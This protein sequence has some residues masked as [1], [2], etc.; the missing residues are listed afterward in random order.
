MAYKKRIN[1]S[2]Y[3]P[4]LA[5]RIRLYTNREQDFIQIQPDKVKP[6]IPKGLF[7]T[8]R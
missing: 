1:Y 4:F 6:T 3:M 5:I 2:F 8:Y 7:A